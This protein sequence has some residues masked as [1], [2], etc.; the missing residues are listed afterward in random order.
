MLNSIDH[1]IKGCCQ[2][3][4][5][6]QRLLYEMFSARMYGVCIRYAGSK[7]D[8]QD[9][10][11]EGF[12][13]I[14]E[15]IEQFEFRGSFEGWIRRIMVNTALEKFRNDN[16]LVR[17]QETIEEFERSEDMDLTENITVK[18]LLRIIEELSPQYRIVFNLYAIEGY[19]H[20]EI[21]KM[22]GITEGTSKSNLSRARTILQ[23]KV[24]E[25]YK[26]VERVG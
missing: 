15:K 2:K 8:A 16:K 14:Y 12:L 10:L 6:A 1:I 5:V 7:E 18:E 19:S 21:S 4:P 17:T 13:K 11:H 25:F 9:I 20:R 22:L 24:N 23:E 3:E 26:H